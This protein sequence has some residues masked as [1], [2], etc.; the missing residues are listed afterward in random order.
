ML[1]PGYA[2]MPTSRFIEGV[3]TMGALKR[4]EKPPRGARGA[5]T[6]E[7]ILLYTIK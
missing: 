2:V 6:L 4:R 3:H 1:D 5:A 7:M